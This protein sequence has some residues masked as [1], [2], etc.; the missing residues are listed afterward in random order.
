MFRVETQVIID[1]PTDVVFAFVADQ[2]NAPQWQRDLA[3]V[4]RVTPGAIGVGTEHDFERVF[5]GRR[6][7][8]RNRVI[9]F[10]AGRGI[11][12]EIPDG[13]LRG[14]ASYH[15]EV[16]PRGTLLTSRMAF[17]ATRLGRLLEPLLARVLRH[18]STRDEVTLKT[19]L[20]TVEAGADPGGA[21]LD[22]PVGPG[23]S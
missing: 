16:V 13:W 5:A 3:A 15:V 1:R 2:T 9:E 18:D 7:V 4:R 11:E 22:A 10:E 23:K 8:S 6:I 12:F 17:E 19:L 14:R 21:S 20:E